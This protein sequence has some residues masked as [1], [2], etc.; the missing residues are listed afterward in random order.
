VEYSVPDLV[1]KRILLVEDEAILAMTE[2][3]QLEKYG[4]SVRTVTTGEKAVDT[5]ETSSDI[6]LIL[7]DINLGTGIDGTVAAERILKNHD[8]P[9]VF[10]SSHT[11]PEIVEKT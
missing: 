3:M 5:V 2:K 4:Y 6:D 10:L 1:N 9:I 11:E 8:I 7:M